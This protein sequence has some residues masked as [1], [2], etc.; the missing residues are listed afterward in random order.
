[1]S[2][3]GSNTYERFAMLEYPV[4]F[5]D[6]APEMAA[7]Y[8]NG[9]YKCLHN[10]LMEICP[11]V[12]KS[13]NGFKVNPQ[14]IEMRGLMTYHNYERYPLG[15]GSIDKAYARWNGLDAVK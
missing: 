10:F 15:S 11:Q 9:E 4:E 13:D 6:Q 7:L 5:Y 14:I 2:Y 3:Q 8:R 1:M 12:V